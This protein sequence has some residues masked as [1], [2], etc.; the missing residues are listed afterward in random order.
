M[1]GAFYA[2]NKKFRV[3]ESQPIA[4]GSGEVRL[5]VAYSGI[6]GSDYHIYLGHMDQR[7]EIPQVVGHETSGEIAEIGEGVEAFKVGNKVVVRPLKP[8]LNCPACCEKHFHFCYNIKVMGVDTPGCFQQSWTVP[9][10]SL[11]HLPDKIDI[12]LAALTEPLAHATNDVRVS[13]L[14]EKDCAVVLGAGPIG[15][16]IALSAKY[17]GARVLATEIS[18]FR[19]NLLKELGVEVVNPL[20]TDVVKRVLEETDNN[21][22]DVVFEVTGSETSAGIM[23][24]LAKMRGHI[25][26][27]GIFNE[28]VKVDLHRVFARQLRFTGVRF[29]TPEDYETAISLIAS[30]VLPLEQI[31]S[32]VRPLEQVQTTFEEIERG[33]NLM[34][35][36]LKCSD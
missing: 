32:A 25:V 13:G 24:K 20:E 31:I 5:K 9:A 12:K 23:T 28:P 21:G 30:G 33:A 36:L 15:T 11:H 14:T 6:C 7:I 10:Y 4:P 26:I 8:C 3:A 2:G 17:K 19:R 34:K 29:Y 35:V 27:V 22:A 16:L 1:K 18:A